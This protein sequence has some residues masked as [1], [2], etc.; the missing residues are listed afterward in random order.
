M[1]SRL[2]NQEIRIIMDTF[3]FFCK[4]DI[5]CTPSPRNGGEIPYVP[6]KLSQERMATWKTMRP[7]LIAGKTQDEDTEYLYLWKSEKKKKK[8]ATEVIR[9]AFQ[10]DRCTS[11]PRLILADSWTGHPRCRRKSN[12]CRRANWNLCLGPEKV[13]KPWSNQ[14]VCMEKGR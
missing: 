4:L 13:W 3:L 11:E 10:N 8:T 5:K 1:L 2:L 12:V 9:L 14:L 7:T 6:W